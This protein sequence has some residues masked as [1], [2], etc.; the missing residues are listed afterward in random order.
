[1]MEFIDTTS[2]AL[3]IIVSIEVKDFGHSIHLRKS[4]R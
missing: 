2:Q 1:M 4:I 3:I